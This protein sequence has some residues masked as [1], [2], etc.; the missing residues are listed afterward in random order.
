MWTKAVWLEG[1]R[2]EEFTIPACWVDKERKLVLWP[3]GKDATK[4]LREQS[5]PT[6]QWLKFPLIKCKV[7]S[8]N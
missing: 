3:D 5:V 4:H 1:G 2:E 7:T 6:I 8:G